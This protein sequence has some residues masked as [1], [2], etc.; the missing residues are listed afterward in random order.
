MDGAIILGARLIPEYVAELLRGEKPF[1]HVASSTASKGG[2][3]CD[4]D[5]SEM[6]R[7]PGKQ[8]E[9]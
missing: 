5:G 7:A 3:G 8:G 1:R 6:R 9:M 4:F 2:R